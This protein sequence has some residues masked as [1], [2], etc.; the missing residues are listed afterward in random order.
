VGVDKAN[1]IFDLH[2]TQQFLLYHHASTGFPPKET[3][4]AAVRA[5]DYA[6]W[7]SPD[8][9][10]MQKGHMK[11]QQKGVWLT[12]VQAPVMIKI[13]PGKQTHFR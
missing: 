13:E 1:T 4:L 12:K 9:D 2:N 11:G 6:T 5:G 8:L 10:E 3:F 7:P